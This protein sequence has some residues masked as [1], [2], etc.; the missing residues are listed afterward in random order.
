MS[1]EKTKAE[2]RTRA[3]QCASKSGQDQEDVQTIKEQD[4]AEA[5]L[6]A[7]RGYGGYIKTETVEAIRATREEAVE[8]ILE[9]SGG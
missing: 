1:E 2:R 6:F 8:N 4:A 3:L 7:R 5:D 9:R